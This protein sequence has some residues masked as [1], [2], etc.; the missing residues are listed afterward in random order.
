MLI[1]ISNGESKAQGLAVSLAFSLSLFLLHPLLHVLR[2]Q[3]AEITLLFMR[4]LKGNLIFAFKNIKNINFLKYARSAFLHLLSGQLY[5]GHGSRIYKW[6]EFLPNGWLLDQSR[7]ES[8][9]TE[10]FK[11][12]CGSVK[13]HTLPS[14]LMH[15]WH[16]VL[17]I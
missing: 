15:L 5:K 11:R 4:M 1:N 7:K 12:T 6:W 14:R 9:L 2:D 10:F 17:R 8:P 3:D 16:M 13:V